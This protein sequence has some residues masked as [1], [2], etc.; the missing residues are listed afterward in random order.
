VDG[1]RGTM[2]KWRKTMKKG[3]KQGGKKKEKGRRE[4]EY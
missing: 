4:G 2:E 3:V 1:E